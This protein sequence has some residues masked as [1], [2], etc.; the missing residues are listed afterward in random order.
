MAANGNGAGGPSPKRQK[1]GGNG[2][3]FPHLENLGDFP[4]RALSKADG[5]AYLVALEAARREAMEVKVQTTM[6]FQRFLNAGMMTQEELADMQKLLRD[7]A[8]T[9][10]LKQSSRVVFIN[11][12]ELGGGVAEMRLDTIALMRDLGARAKWLVMDGA[13]RF[14]K[15]TVHMHEGIQNSH[16]VPLEAH[17]TEVFQ[18]TTIQNFLRLEQ[19]HHPSE[20]DVLWIDDPQPLGIATLVKTLFPRTVVIWRCHVHVDAE[21]SVK[22]FINDMATGSLQPERDHLLL[23]FLA[24]RGHHGPVRGVDLQVFHRTSFAENLG[25]PSAR[26][27]IMPPCINPLSFKNMEVNDA[28]V[29]ATLVKYGVMPGPRVGRDARVPPFVLEV[30]R[31][32]PYKGPLELITAFR[33]AVRRLPEDIQREIR[34]VLVSS[35]PGDNPSGVRLARQLQE[36]VDS[37][38]LSGF[39]ADQQAGAPRDLRK[40]IVLLMLDDKAPWERLVERLRRES[41]Y[42]P[43]RLEG[44]SREVRE[45]ANLPIP[46]AV[47]SLEHCGLIPPSLVPKLLKDPLPSGVVFTAEQKSAMLEVLL[48]CRSRRQPGGTAVTRR[49]AE[50]DSLTGKEI[51]AFEVNALQ[52]AALVTVQFSSK[53]GFGLTVSESLVKSLPGYEHV[54]VT[55]LVGGLRP[56][57]EACEC[58]KIEYPPDEATAS[59]E[60]YR[61]LPEHPV[62]PYL[63]SLAARI[64][65]R[66]SVRKLEEHLLTATKMP[67][68][69]RLR[70]SEAARKGVL[71]NF[72][73]WANVHDISRGI[74]K[75]SK[76]AAAVHK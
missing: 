13:E 74:A 63:R 8:T 64:A 58:L 60:E 21:A 19:E 16:H 59:L 14:F 65:A 37:L 33:E 49:R 44:I 47:A 45:L 1:V 6:C 50:Q 30:S 41:G 29:E 39:P 5:E 27:H 20:I 10:Q 68:D 71:K 42:D 9:C 26:A 32:D 55:T 52:S 72:S 76:L 43:D 40:R 31:F 53:E 35:L 2:C 67:V 12:T 25:V 56:Q 22:S 73:T 48:D 28:L 69:E 15:V 54:L 51:N 11:A 4:L 38:D 61:K 46:E 17:E 62:E 57:A 75:A 36:F 23:A 70:M 18:L 66:S 24:S 3:S 7:A 34:L